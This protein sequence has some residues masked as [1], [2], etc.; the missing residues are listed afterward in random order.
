ME[1]EEKREGAWGER[2]GRSWSR[3]G[4]RRG[5]FVYMYKQSDSLV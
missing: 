5:R 1:R 4:S 2:G 3:E